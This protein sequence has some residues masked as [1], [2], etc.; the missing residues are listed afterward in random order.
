[1]RARHVCL[2]VAS[3]GSRM[4]TPGPRKG[5]FSSFLVYS[6]LYYLDGTT[7]ITRNAHNMAEDLTTL[8]LKHLGD[9]QQALGKMEGLGERLMEIKDKVDK[10]DAS[11][12][13][14]DGKVKLMSKQQEE[15]HDRIFGDG[16]IAD[17]V[18]QHEKVT[19]GIKALKPAA[20]TLFAIL[21]TLMF[22]FF[23][24][25]FHQQTVV[26]DIPDSGQKKQVTIGY[27]MPAIDDENKKLLIDLI[28]QIIGEQAKGNI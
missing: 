25:T 16:G 28:K 1:M 19:T 5:A 12:T 11:V 4:K 15:D 17:Q 9:I 3:H 6:Q 7:T 2:H 24:G 10:I 20:T 23:L 22:N 8:V 21:I 13:E 14:L 18:D 26:E 27:K